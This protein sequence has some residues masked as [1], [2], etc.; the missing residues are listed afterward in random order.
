MRLDPEMRRG[1]Q[2]AS[3]QACQGSS[4]G[5]LVRSRP[6]SSSPRGPF[7]C[8]TEARALFATEESHGRRGSLR[9]L[10]CQPV[11]MEPGIGGLTTG[12]CL[13]PHRTTEISFSNCD[14]G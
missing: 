10:G 1:S 4:L 6:W 7:S 8:E 12:R 14:W 5:S 11:A 3:L 13:S 2:A 9:D